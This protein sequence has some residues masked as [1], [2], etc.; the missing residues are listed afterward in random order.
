M[1]TTQH[2][3]AAD[4]RFAIAADRQKTLARQVTPLRSAIA[5]VW[6]AL[7]LAW[8]AVAGFMLVGA[9]VSL[10][11]GPVFEEEL[12]GPVADGA[13]DSPWEGWWGVG[14]A[15]AFVLIGALSIWSA[16]RAQSR[17]GMLPNQTMQTDD[18]S[19]HG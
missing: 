13:P 15:V 3:N 17:W 11:R 18:A 5:F 2:A 6:I 14:L 4:D 8:T 9:V 19:R 1:V 16:L 7:S 12:W 10:I